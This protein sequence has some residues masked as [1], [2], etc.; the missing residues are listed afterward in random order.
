MR[1]ILRSSNSL[2]KTPTSKLIPLSGGGGAEESNADEK[3]M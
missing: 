1:F 3:A 2:P